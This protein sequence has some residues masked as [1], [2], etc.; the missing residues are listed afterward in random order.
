MRLA[1]GPTIH[2]HWTSYDAKNHRL[3]VAGYGEDGLY[4]LNFGPNTDAPAMSTA[5]HDDGANLDSTSVVCIRR[6]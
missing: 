1:L 4:T 5:F 6:T 3:A 2:P